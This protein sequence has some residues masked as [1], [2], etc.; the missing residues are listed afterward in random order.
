MVERERSTCGGVIAPC[1]AASSLR[2]VR[3]RWVFGFLHAFRDW[4]SVPIVP[5]DRVHIDYVLTQIVSEY[6]LWLCRT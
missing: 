1:A 3:D 6:L 4:I 2:P 5:D